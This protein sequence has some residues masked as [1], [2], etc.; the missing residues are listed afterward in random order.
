MVILPELPILEAHQ[1]LLAE[2]PGVIVDAPG[3]VESAPLRFSL[4]D[5][6]RRGRYLAALQAPTY[7]RAAAW[8][9]EQVLPQLP[10]VLDEI[11]VGLTGND[12]W[13]EFARSQGDWASGIQRRTR[14]KIAAFDRLLAMGEQQGLLYRLPRWFEPGSERQ[15]AHKL[16]LN[17][18]GLLHRLLGWD[19]RTYLEGPAAVGPGLTDRFWRQR[20][21]SWEGFVVSS[22]VRA[23][24]PR[25]KA[26]VWEDNPGE[27]DLILDWNREAWAIEITRGRNKKFRDLHGQGHRATGATRP[28]IL[29]FDDEVGLPE[30]K[31]SL[32]HQ[33][34]CM[35]LR[36]AL[37]EVQRRTT[38]S[39]LRA[40]RSLPSPALCLA[41]ARLLGRAHPSEKSR[42]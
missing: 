18:P 31:G 30:L 26:S 11:P 37:R 15:D 24:G 1:L 21:K 8:L 10:V 35:T 39:T 29:V 25:A 6:R 14:M 3:E 22:L 33:V 34:E 16:Y 7:D 40:S 38:P 32:R 36:E 41:R 23:A 13:N 5:L 2:P 9:G 17:D 27:I 28:I 20:D 42:R 4:A 19:E 12:I